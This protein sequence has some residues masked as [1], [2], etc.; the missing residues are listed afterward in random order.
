MVLEPEI[1]IVLERGRRLLGDPWAQRAILVAVVVWVFWDGIWAGVPRSDHILYLHHI[2]QFDGLWDILAHSPAWN[3]DAANPGDDVVLYR[4]VLYLLLGTL[5]YFFRYDFAAWQIAALCLH[6]AVVLG[7]HLLLMQ[8]RL[9]Q[10]LL[11]L[12]I[13]L[14]FA[15]TFFASELV[16]WNHIV[17]YVLFCALDV[18]AVYFFL[19][20]LQSDRSVFLI[21]CC[22]LSV[23]AEFTYE[24]GAVVN[25]LFAAALFARSWSASASDAP[26]P[27][28]PRNASRWFALLFLL[29]A[30]VLPMASLLDL[31]ARGVA[32][33]PGV[34]GMGI[35]RMAVLAGQ[36]A[37]LQIAFWLSTWLAPT[38]YHCTAL[39]RAVCGVSPTGLTLLRLLNLI[40]LAL[41]AT[42]AV[43]GWKQLARSNISRREPLFALAASTIFLLA[44]SVIIAIG[45]TLPD[46]LM[47][48][49]QANVYYTYIACLTVCV[50]IA[51]AM[52]VGRVRV[53]PID[54]EAASTRAGAKTGSEGS[55]PRPELGRRLVPALLVLAL[56][57]ACGVREL[58]RAFRYEY[59]A[60]RQQVIDRVLA[61]RKQVGDR[62][63]RYFVVGPTCTGNETISWFTQGRLRKNSGWQPPVTLADAL[64][65]ER[66]A[67]LNAARIRID[68]ESV[69]EIRCDS[70]VA[71]Q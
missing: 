40:A 32:F 61:W 39:A 46:R 33:S 10:T 24:A 28:S 44:Y 13:S 11:P 27:G 8:G 64:W 4:P 43:Q 56:V 20:F 60:P 34:H 36:D 50:G 67:N 26:V 25:V 6:I 15:C 2:S 3:R 7:L 17:G 47:F 19:R 53:A 52:A 29:A 57:N 9:R 22:A 69:D 62:V 30:V 55:A 66:S 37:L 21:P 42:G 12:A 71:S 23:V 1:G 14:W 59:A 16:F 54:L 65:P 48:V 18:Y 41:L 51:T 35:G 49:L 58:A 45:R 38:V 31:R 70:T 63:P 68:L 5:Y